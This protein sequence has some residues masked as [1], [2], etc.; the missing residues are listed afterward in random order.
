MALVYIPPGT[1][2]MGSPAR[3]P[4][5]GEDELPAHKLTVS[6]GFTM[7]A[8]EVSNAQFRQFRPKHTSGRYVDHDLNGDRQ[9]AVEVTW[10]AAQA[11]CQWLGAREGRRYRLP[12]EAEWEYACRA[13]TTT[14]Y[15]WGNDPDVGQGWCNGHDATARRTHGFRWTA[16]RWD[17]AYAVS[18]P[19]GRFRGNAWGLCDMHGNVSE[20]CADWYAKSYYARS[21]L[22]D[23]AG[24]TET[25]AATFAEGRARVLRGGSWYQ[26]PDVCRSA[27][28]DWTQPSRSLH[29]VG[30]R[31][32]CEMAAPDK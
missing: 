23:P 19:V 32:V 14:Y 30:F 21:P 26:R 8:C 18:S 20:W 1:F 10:D 25:R 4:Q 16:F 5:V 2:W 17:D 13:G 9:P 3:D 24:P 11:F 29:L 12:T 6:K 22:I 27:K 7:S 28:R 31:V 15:Q